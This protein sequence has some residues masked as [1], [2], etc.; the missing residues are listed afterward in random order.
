MKP[1]LAV[2]RT[3]AR[4]RLAHGTADAEVPFRHVEELAEAAGSRATLVR[5]EGLGHND[6]RPPQ[7]V[8]ALARFLRE[9]VR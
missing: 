8:A 5:L 3:T 4:L 6:P 1:I 2:A 7:E 9:A